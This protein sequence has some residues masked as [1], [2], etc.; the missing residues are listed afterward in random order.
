VLVQE[1]QGRHPCPGRSAHKRTTIDLHLVNSPC[2]RFASGTVSGG[3]I[4][5]A[6]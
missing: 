3:P 6:R 4:S 5:I 1:T 2:K